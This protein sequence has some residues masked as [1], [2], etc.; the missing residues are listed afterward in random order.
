[1]EKA[2]ILTLLEQEL[3]EAR[4]WRDRASALFDR[5]LQESAAHTSL[6]SGRVQETSKEYSAALSAVQ[7]ALK[8][9][10]DFVIAGA[11]PATPKPPLPEA[12]PSKRGTAG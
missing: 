9:Y 1:M 10:N 8:R 5:A 3:H 2:Q 6:Y 11:V 12:L 7:E 4:D